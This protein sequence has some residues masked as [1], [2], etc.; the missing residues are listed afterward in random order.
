MVCQEDN[1]SFRW[2]DRNGAV[3][4]AAY[5]F[6]LGREN[7][8]KYCAK[9]PQSEIN[10]YRNIFNN[11]NWV[12]KPVVDERMYIEGASFVLGASPKFKDYYCLNHEK[13][14]ARQWTQF[15]GDV[16]REV[17]SR[18]YMKRE[19]ARLKQMLEKNSAKC[20]S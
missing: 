19:L 7:L 18:D 11:P 1:M 17:A 15:L 20:N 10:Y 4:Q 3:N 12:P 6:I 16:K 5:Q 14:T 2:K 8:E 13:M 9:M